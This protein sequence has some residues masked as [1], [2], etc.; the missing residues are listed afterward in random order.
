MVD[1]RYAPPE[2]SV[3]QD[4]LS[5]IQQKINKIGK[6]CVAAQ[7]EGLSKRSE[8][9]RSQ[10]RH[11]LHHVALLHESVPA[12]IEEL[13]RSTTFGRMCFT[14]LLSWHVH[15]GI[16]RNPFFF[17]RDRTTISNW[18]EVFSHVD[19]LAHGGM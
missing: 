4:Q 5:D 17:M 10:L 19:Q 3:I 9:E 15:C 12:M 18:Y 14:A 8:E 7:V 1:P 16:F 11:E 6:D 13:K 2:D